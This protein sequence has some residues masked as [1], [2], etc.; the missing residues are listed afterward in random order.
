MTRPHQ[1]FGFK[2]HISRQ[3]PK[4]AMAW[5]LVVLAAWV[6]LAGVYVLQITNAAPRSD[7]LQTLES[8]I[9]EL[10]LE[11]T[12]SEDQIARQSSMH[13][14]TER[15]RSLGFVEMENPNFVN[16][17]SHAFVRR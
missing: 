16:P 4:G 11:V 5:A 9:D 8:R 10:K 3:L 1:R 15:A 13:S 17:A 7:R 6:M 2:E 12:A 14:L